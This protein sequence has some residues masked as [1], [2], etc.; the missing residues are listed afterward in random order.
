M[1]GLFA[2][3]KDISEKEHHEIFD[4]FAKYDSWLEKLGLLSSRGFWQLL[5]D[6][7]GYPANKPPWGGIAKID[8]V[9]GKK[10]WSIPMGHRLDAEKNKYNKKIILNFDTEAID[11]SASP[12]KPRVFIENKLSSVSFDVACLLTDSGN[13]SLLIPFPLSTIFISV[14]PLCFDFFL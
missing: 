2:D 6:K 12:L 10:I 14:F 7:D 5:L 3:A 9:T 11:G 1:N 8:L 13:S 4:Q